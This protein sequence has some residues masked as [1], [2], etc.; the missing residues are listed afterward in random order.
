MIAGYPRIFLAALAACLPAFPLFAENAEP[1]TASHHTLTLEQAYDRTLASDQSIQVAWYELRK[2][3]LQPWS[4][5]TRLGPLLTGNSGRTVDKTTT[6]GTVFSGFP[7]TTVSRTVAGSAGLSFEQPI[8]DLTTIPAYRLGKLTVQA[9]RLTYKSTIRQVLYGVA[10]AYYEVLKQQRVAAIDRETLEMANQQLDLA[11]KRADAGEVK[12]TDVL[13]A[14]VTVENDRQTMIESENTLLSN[15]N[16]LANTLNLDPAMAADLQLADPPDYPPVLPPFEDLLSQAYRRRED[17]LVKAVAIDQDIERRSGVVA[18]Y[19]P[20]VAAQWNGSYN[21]TTGS[22]ANRA[23]GWNAAV[24]VSVPFLTGGQREIDLRAAGHNIS[25]SKLNYASFAKT[26]Q[27]DVKDAWLN[28]RSLEQT[29]KAIGV[30]LEAAQQ[31][32]EDTQNQYRE[33]EATNLDVLTA[34]NALNVS[35]KDFT[36]QRYSYQVALRDLEETSGSFQDERVKKLKFQ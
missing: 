11:Q 7:S 33:G 24:A 13:N 6:D 18:E 14:R 16:V 23:H 19:Y 35:R 12:R 1:G 15:R 28:V 20:T 21:D 34:L 22:G 30:Q 31:S 2:A 17:L 4:A 29:L 8:L 25:E 36:F 9:A 26:V 3:K 5:L 32:Y 27:Q 10:T